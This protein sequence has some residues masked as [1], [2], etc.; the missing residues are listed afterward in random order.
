MSGFARARVLQRAFGHDCPAAPIAPTEEQRVLW[1]KLLLE[2]TLETIE[3]GLGLGLYHR[4]TRGYIHS[5]Q[6]EVVPLGVAYDSVET[7]DGIADVKVIANG[8]GAVFGLPVE[9]ADAEVFRS[10]MSKLGEDGKPVINDGIIDPTQPIGKRLK[11]P[12]YSP[13]DIKGLLS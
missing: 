5:S 2:E 3:K 10:N 12:N 7:L 1:A 6:V 8:M 11:G 13:A 4:S 9:A